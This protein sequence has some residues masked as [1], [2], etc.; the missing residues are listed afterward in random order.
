MKSSEKNYQTFYSNEKKALDKEFSKMFLKKT[1]VS[2]YEPCAYIMDNGGKRLRPLL[3]L[4]SC[5]A[6]GGDYK[7]AR[8]AALAV[9]IL[10]NFTLVHDDIMDNAD[11]RRGMATLHK[12]YDISTAILAGDNLIAFAYQYLL[13]DCHENVKEV[14]ATFTKGIVEVCEG[15]SLDKEFELKK[16]VKIKDYIEMIQKKTAA[17]LQICCSI[18]A[19]IAGASKNEIKK[20]SDFGLNIGLAFQI[21]DDLLDIFGDE[22]EFGKTVGGD[23][24][25]GKKTYLVLKA[26]EKAVGADKVLLDKFI[27]NKGIKRTE[28]AKFKS[29]Y[30]KLG[31]FDDAEKEIKKYTTKAL[32]ALKDLK[33][34]ESVL[35][36]N[37]LANSLITRTK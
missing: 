13:L 24:I 17:L 26:L 37:S 3:V 34:E 22:K 25:E 31:I 18:G 16:E 20:L 29:L 19:Q 2:L 12:K 23:L 35:L 4:L 33:D 10:H 30:V 5:R 21:Q 11:K 1:P 6:A 7:K 9:E 32:N 15:Q 8:N 14:V 36:M 28:V 27:E